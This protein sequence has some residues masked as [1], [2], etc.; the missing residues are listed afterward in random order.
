MT[1]QALDPAWLPV[2][3]DVARGALGRRDRQGFA[4]VEE[5][6]SLSELYTRG[7]SRLSG[8][9]QHLAARLRF[10]LPRDLPKIEGPLLELHAQGALPAGPRWRV[11]DLGA[12]LGTT[13]LGA[14]GVAR[15]LGVEGLDVTAVELDAPS[16]E[17]MQALC[18]RAGEGP[19]TEVCAP[20]KLKSVV[21]DV[22]RIDP[23]ANGPYDLI[24]LGL[25]LNELA[26][27]RLDRRLGL[28]R[29]WLRL[30]APG[31]A[32]VIL[33]P[34]LREVSRD[35]QRLRDALVQARVSVRAPCTHRG[36]CPMLA[37]ERDWCS[38]ELKVPLPPP[39]A[40]LA[41]GAGLRWERLTAAWLVLGEEPAAPLGDY[42]V[43]GG[44]I[45]SKG[46]CDW[47]VC[48][49]AGLVKL[50]RLNRFRGEGDPLEGARRGS[51]LAF[52]GPV[53]EK[54]RADKVGV[55]RLR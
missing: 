9:T 15:R 10:Y 44:P 8:Q 31:G 14:A 3:D 37:R 42:R 54:V 16:L 52:D 32:L 48:G 39:L 21:A 47:Q 28:V 22:E 11:L 45:E 40:E 50:G 53:G 23:S 2:L 12:G 33:E 49:E 34:A 27:G 36:P 51:L 46:R 1:P 7:R 4:L 30:L 29:R 17:L 41:R 55:R 6:R 24:L 38:G 19:L 35:L 20:V 43:V 13:T 25:S 5:I 26:G 18:A